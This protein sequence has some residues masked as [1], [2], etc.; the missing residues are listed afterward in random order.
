[1]PDLM[2]LG[3]GRHAIET[4]YLMED[5]GIHTNVVAFVQDEAV[6]NQQLIGLPVI[7]RDAVLSRYTNSELQKPRLIGAI[8]NIPDNKRLLG[9]FKD[10]GFSFFSAVIPSVKRHRQ[11]YFGEGIIVAQGSV[12][13][14]NVA[15]EDHAMINIGCTLSHDVYI[16]KYVNM[17]PGTHLAGF[18]KIEDEVF[19]GTG[20]TIVPKVTVGKGAYIAAGTCV[21]KDVPPYSMVAGVP[22]VVKRKLID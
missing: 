4:Y 19:I 14:Y 12:I 11:K 10:A 20:V 6:E 1:M 18:V 13:S 17:S 8:G 9:I 5:L 15:I 16:G 2:I 21:T 7:K 3:G 22:G